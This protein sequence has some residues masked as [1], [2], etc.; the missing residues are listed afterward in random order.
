M[1][2]PTKMTLAELRALRPVVPEARQVVIR[3]VDNDKP[4]EESA[5][6]IRANIFGFVDRGHR[7]FASA[8]SAMEFLHQS[9][10]VAR[11]YLAARLLCPKGKRLAKLYCLP[12]HVESVADAGGADCW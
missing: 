8:A 3:N 9:D 10:R 2:R 11:T 12:A 1:S 4:P 7:H 5:E 6:R